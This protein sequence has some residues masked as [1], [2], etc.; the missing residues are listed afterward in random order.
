[1]NNP[2]HHSSCDICQLSPFC[3]EDKNCALSTRCLPLP[4]DR[5]IKLKRGETLSWSSDKFEHLYA[6]QQGAMKTFQTNADG[7]EIIHG[8]Y[9]AGEVLGYEAINTGYYPFSAAA[10]CDTEVCEIPFAAML[11]LLESRPAL[12]KHIINLLSH[13]LTS[14]QYLKTSAEQRL[15]AFLID[16]SSRLHADKNNLEFSLPMTREDIGNYLRLTPETVSRICSRFTA[17]QIIKSEYKK[18]RL[19]DLDKLRLIAD[20]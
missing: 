7:N 5:Q 4:T 13:Q 16:L 8:F 2:G 10:L 11:E 17:N 1:M 9:F 6:I 14:S 18:F 12:Q 20:E 3:M 15:A 19:I